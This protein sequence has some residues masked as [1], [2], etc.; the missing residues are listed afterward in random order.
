MN[1]LLRGLASYATDE[2]H[3]YLRSQVTRSVAETVTASA[4]VFVATGSYAAA[5]FGAA[6]LYAVMGMRVHRRLW[7][8]W[9]TA[10]RFDREQEGG[11]LD[12]DRDGSLSGRLESAARRDEADDSS[13]FVYDMQPT[14]A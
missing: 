6:G 2:E 3:A 11:F 12:P 10:R 7:Q 13:S 1:S 5:A 14:A 8:D 9:R 4:G